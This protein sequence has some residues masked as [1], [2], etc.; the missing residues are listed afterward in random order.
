MCP[1]IDAIKMI[2]PPVFCSIMIR[3][4]ACAQR[5]VPVRLISIS[6]LNFSTSYVSA[7][8]LELYSSIIYPAVLVKYTYSAIPAEQ[9]KISTPP[10]SLAIYSCISS[11]FKLLCQQF[12]RLD[13]HC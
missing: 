5:K 11:S 13:I 4:A 1:D 3:P 12:L 10:R 6:L 2:E 9:I 7:G 8:M